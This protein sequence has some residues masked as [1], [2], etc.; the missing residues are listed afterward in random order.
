ML[1]LSQTGKPKAAL[2]GIILTACEVAGGELEGHAGV[3]E[4]LEA[5][6]GLKV[7]ESAVAEALE[8]L[9]GTGE[10]LPTRDGSRFRLS[11]AAKAMV[12]ER[13]EAGQQLE[14]LVRREWL[15]S[16]AAVGLPVD[17]VEAVLW[18][19]LR[20]YMAKVFREHGALSVELLAYTGARD[21]REFGT[22]DG[23][24]DAALSEE[25]CPDP[26][27]AR[28]AIQ[29]FFAEQTAAR[30][31]YV[32]QLLDGTFTF[33]ALSIHEAT[34]Q[35]LRPTIPE[36]SIFLDTNFIFELLGL[37]RSPGSGDTARE[38]IS[39]IKNNAFP[40]KLY[41]HSETLT[42]V[43]RTIGS[44]GRNALEGRRFP[45]EI[46]RAAISPQR[47]LGAL[48]GLEVA[49]HQLNAETQVEPKTFLDKYRNVEPLLKEF[50]ITLYREPFNESPKDSNEKGL[51]VAEYKTFVEERRPAKK[52]DALDH[53]VTVWMAVQQKRR[54]ARTTLEGGALFL[55]VDYVLFNFDRQFLA[56][57][58]GGP[59]SIA[60]PNQLLQ[61]LRPYATPSGDFDARFVA[62]FGVNELRTAY[63][64]Y[65]P[66]TSKMLSILATY[67]D[68]PERVAV[69]LLTDLVLVAEL[70]A[71][72]DD[73]DLLREKI[74]SAVFRKNAELQNERE[75]ADRLRVEASAGFEERLAH[76][77]RELQ[78]V[79]D[80]AAAADARRQEELAAAD[81]AAD[82]ELAAAKNGCAPNQSP[83]WIEQILGPVPRSLHWCSPLAW[84]LSS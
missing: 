31:K 3:I 33:F 12:L 67:K 29:M 51:L 41:M 65:G 47:L 38:L 32:A 52:Y 18:A 17:G 27:L 35:Y 80:A 57:H 9:R 64:D 81:A 14:D 42:E 30:A 13:T 68:V 77:E 59:Q 1:S 15:D 23:A 6:F 26:A 36:L 83:Q 22:L 71:M 82:L 66:T 45:Q 20:K 78:D 2:A 75:R 54:A 73:N 84:P 46:S 11:P 74:E 43:E 37:S 40:F 61:V 7:G 56:A 49:Y 28:Q 25:R 69:E 72:P 79:K 62:S 4:A 63:S 24:L 55:T 21:D 76:T 39:F 53:D 44:I 60:L 19:S 10:L 8:Y 70:E 34:A 58:S 16:L 50:G 5:V 48:S